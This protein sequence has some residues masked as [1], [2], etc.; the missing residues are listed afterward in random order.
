MPREYNIIAS[1]WGLGTD[2]IPRR[3]LCTDQWRIVEQ[4]GGEEVGDET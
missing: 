1:H 3:I 2:R 4:G